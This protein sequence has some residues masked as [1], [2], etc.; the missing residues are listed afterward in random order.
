MSELIIEFKFKI[1][2]KGELCF[3]DATDSF[4]FRVNL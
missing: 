3:F 2:S 4:C 1:Y